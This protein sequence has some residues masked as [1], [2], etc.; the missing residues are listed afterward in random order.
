MSHR[1][2]H[3]GAKDGPFRPYPKLWAA[4]A[5]EP[6]IIDALE[7]GGLNFDHLT[8]ASKRHAMRG[9]DEAREYIAATANITVVPPAHHTKGQDDAP[10]DAGHDERAT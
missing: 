3:Q 4:F 5:D 10:P 7:R 2:H 9:K 8:E 1:H 6:A